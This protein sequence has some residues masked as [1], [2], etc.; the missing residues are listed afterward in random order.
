MSTPRPPMPAGTAT[1]M[2][3]TTFATTPGAQP[4]QARPA[5]PD[6]LA[7]LC[8]L[9]FPELPPV[10]PGE[11]VWV[12]GPTGAEGAPVPALATLR[13]RRRIG[14]PVP[15]AWFRLGWAVHAASELG[16]Y[17]RQ[18]T[19][20]LGHD[21]T[22]ADELT[23]FGLAP[24]LPA[25]EAG[26]AW[27]A[28]VAAAVQALAPDQADGDGGEPAPCIAEL[29]GM[30]EADGGSPVWHGLGRHF[31]GQAL[32]ALRRQ[33]GAEG[34]HHLAGLMPRQVVY[35]AL[36]PAATQAAFGQVAAAALPLRQAL[37][38]QGFGA[39]DH[40]AITDGGAVLERWAE[41]AL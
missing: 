29:P 19:L 35:A 36:L 41:A 1:P 39:R 10:A 13:L 31:H 37:Q 12:A 32:E 28:L 6:D 18:R 9:D 33:H 40:V 23:G 15:R 30:R 20:L 2:A 34:L 11:V 8:G 7:G 16:L 3:T 38:A 27:A 25:A 4:W 5:G 21:L 24:S 22:G 17:R 26:P 14:R